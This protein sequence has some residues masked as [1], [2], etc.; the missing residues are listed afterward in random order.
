MSGLETIMAPGIYYPAIKSAWV[1]IFKKSL[2]HNFLVINVLNCLISY[3]NV[4]NIFIIC[5]DVYISHIK[6]HHGGL[7]LIRG[8][9]EIERT[10]IFPPPHPEYS[11][12]APVQTHGAI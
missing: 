5:L 3:I 12:N 11:Y 7:Q 4:L 10:V 8:Y 2:L 1:W 6:V 9:T